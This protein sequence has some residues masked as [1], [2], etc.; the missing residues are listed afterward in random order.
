MN[1]LI[2]S[3]L[4]E[5]V[6]LTPTDLLSDVVTYVIISDVQV[7]SHQHV[8]STLM[9]SFEIF[10]NHLTLDIHMRI[11]SIY[12]CSSKYFLLQY[13]LQGI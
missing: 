8:Q 13:F 3:Y 4:N 2:T 11:S 10:L 7:N 12:H 1:E 5:G 9:L 6:R